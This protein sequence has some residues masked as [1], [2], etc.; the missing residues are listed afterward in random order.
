MLPG[1]GMDIAWASYKST[2]VSFN[3]KTAVVAP[4]Y[5]DPNGTQWLRS[6]FGG[7]LTTCGLS[8][9]GKPSERTHNFLG[10]QEIELHGLISNSAS[11]LV[12]VSESWNGNDLVISVS[13]RVKEAE[14]FGEYLVLSRT[15]ST[16]A[17]ENRLFLKDTIENLS[18][19][20][21]PVML[22][23]HINAGYPLLDGGAEFLAKSNGIT[24]ANTYAESKIKNYPLMDEPRTNA[25]ELVYYH[26]L[27][28]DE[29]NLCADSGR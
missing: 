7:L 23:Y 12:S 14:T 25:G 29:D 9:V 20:E 13:G 27:A 19:Y 26:D 17:G 4:A 10:N 5:Y 18:P 11:D 16:V 28:A 1:R 3:A 24:A 2:P 15:I 6:F 8:N 22:L 21:A